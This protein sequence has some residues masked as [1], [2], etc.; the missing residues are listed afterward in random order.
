MTRRTE[1]VLVEQHLSNSPQTEIYFHLSPIC[2][3]LDDPPSSQLNLFIWLLHYRE[4]GAQLKD[5][6]SLNQCR[7]DALWR[8]FS[9]I[10][11]KTCRN[12]AADCMR[13]SVSIQCAIYDSDILDTIVQRQKQQNKHKATFPSLWVNSPHLT[14]CYCHTLDSRER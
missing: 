8:H 5:E 1:G 9:V 12:T 3:S 6:L 7:L 11:S 14:N 4:H 13:R 10:C 2:E